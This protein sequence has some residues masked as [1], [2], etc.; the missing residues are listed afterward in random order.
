[1]HNI[2]A[3]ENWN[4]RERKREIVEYWLHLYAHINDQSYLIKEIHSMHV[5]DEQETTLLKNKYNPYSVG[6]DHPPNH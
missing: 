6:M 2:N 3:K 4:K 5:I 1:V